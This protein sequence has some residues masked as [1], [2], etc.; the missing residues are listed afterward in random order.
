MEKEEQGQR[1]QWEQAWHIQE[2]GRKLVFQVYHCPVELSVIIEISELSNMVATNHICL[3]D[4][5]NVTR[6]N[7]ELSFIIYLRLVDLATCG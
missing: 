4:T 2:T 1:L 3:L 5:C 6:V 7:E